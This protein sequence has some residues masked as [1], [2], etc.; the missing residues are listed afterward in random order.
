MRQLWLV[1]SLLASEITVTALPA[2]VVLLRHAEKPSDDRNPN[3]SARGFQRAMALPTLLT[4]TPALTRGGIPT[5]IFAPRPTAHGHSRRASETITPTARA[6]HL[7]VL[8]PFSA[9]EY[10]AL[11]KEILS[12]PAFDGKTI[13]ICWVHDYLPQLAREFGV[14]H[15]PGWSGDTFDRVWAI[16]FT[17]RRAT[18][19]NLPQHLLAGDSTD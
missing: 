19:Q 1:V 12:N 5:A 8:T 10:A 9:N 15:P 2:E 11:A 3:L 16:T 17:G 4:N 14:R 18:L 13:L 6:L 7:P